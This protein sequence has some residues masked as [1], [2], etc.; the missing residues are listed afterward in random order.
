MDALFLDHYDRELAYLR[1]LGG[2]FAEQYPKIAGNLGMDKFSCADPAVE[3][4][5]EG[6]A[7]MAARVQRRLDSEFPQLT[8]GLLDTVFPH[9]TRPIPSAAM[10]Q[11][12]PD[13]DSSSLAAGYKIPKGTRLYAQAAPGQSTACRFDTTSETTLWPVR[14][15][16][17]EFFTRERAV[18][19]PLPKE[20]HKQGMRTGLRLTL[21]S[22]GGLTFNQLQLDNLRIYLQGGE[23]AQQLYETLVCSTKLFAVGATGSGR[24]WH[25]MA[26]NQVG[27]YG[28][29]FADALLP[30]EPRSFFGYRLL[31]EYFMLP[32]KFLFINLSGLKPVLEQVEGNE[33]RIVLGFDSHEQSLA[34]RVS[35]EH[36]ALHVVPA[37]NLFQQRADRM[38]VNHQKSEQ[39]LIVDRSRPLDFEI[40][41]IEKMQGHSTNRK[42][43]V[44]F[45]PLYAP[46]A[47]DSDRQRHATYY[48]HERRTRLDSSFS[49]ER[50]SF[51]PGTELFIN[52]TD[53]HQEP[54]RHQVQQL[55]ATVYCTNR[56]LPLL[57]PE[58]G[59]REAF[60]AESAA[61]IRQVLC[62]GGPTKPGAPLVGDDGETAWRLI[63]HLTPNYLS[64]QDNASGGAAML[65]E[66][67]SL[68]CA[69]YDHTARRQIEGLLSIESKQVV[70]RLPFA[71]PVTHGHG[72]SI[73]LQCDEDGF[74]GRGVF[75]L[76]SVLEQ[77]FSR[78]ATINSFTETSL[79]T[80]K[81]GPVHRWP[82]RIGDAPVI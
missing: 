24:G 48:T 57:P 81:R 78:Y 9:Y 70:R 38:H 21:E 25:C 6:F 63:S 45:L 11:L 60:H 44:P 55:S 43:D 56:D 7:F 30:H 72:V 59:W 82:V 58:Q 47:F 71:G 62:I 39:H 2:E 61:P 22:M 65:R 75:L 79:S 69:P 20:F 54:F 5:L 41:S 16:E 51:Y 27:P 4:L 46:P 74:E 23:I 68:Y 18:G 67:L 8:R 13:F 42:E 17:A 50:R 26:A 35:N 53:S 52:I 66:L 64:L 28:F 49:K 19:Y 32:E 29:D 10:F 14:I 40:W 12:E 3:R 80:V 31:Q 76:G 37:V 1:E 34:G 33:C 15:S 73:H 36:L 77:F